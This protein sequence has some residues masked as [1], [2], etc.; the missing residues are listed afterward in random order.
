[1]H[2]ARVSYSELFIV[3]LDVDGKAIP[4]ESNLGEVTVSADLMVRLERCRG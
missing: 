4:P 1:V 3:H 2:G